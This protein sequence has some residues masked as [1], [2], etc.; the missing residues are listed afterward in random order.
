M[1]ESKRDPLTFDLPPNATFDVLRV[2]IAEE[3]DC[4]PDSQQMYLGFVPIES[5]QIVKESCSSGDTITVLIW[6][7]AA[8]EN[9]TFSMRVEDTIMIILGP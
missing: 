8:F 4:E 1:E 7:Q 9:T 5:S 3:E 2:M 6:K